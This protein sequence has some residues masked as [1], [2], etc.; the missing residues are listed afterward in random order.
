LEKKIEVRFFYYLFSQ[1]YWSLNRKQRCRNVWAR[2]FRDARIFDKSK[3]L[4]C[5]C[6]FCIAN[7][8]ITGNKVKHAQRWFVG[9]LQFYAVLCCHNTRS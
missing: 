4:G 7:S 9:E 2:I 3:L 6:I 8:Y 5:A 1:P